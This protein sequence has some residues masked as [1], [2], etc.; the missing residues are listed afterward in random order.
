MGWICQLHNFKFILVNSAITCSGR[1]LTDVTLGQITNSLKS[2]KLS[3]AIFRCLFLA[4]FRFNLTY[5][6]NLV[7]FLVTLKKLFN[8][9][10]D[11]LRNVSGST[12]VL[13]RA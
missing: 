2:R 11:S 3:Y 13:D 8:L 7:S 4:I 5:D 1:I 10:S 6:L 12:Q 9:S